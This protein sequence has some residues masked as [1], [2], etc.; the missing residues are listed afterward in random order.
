MIRQQNNIVFDWFDD[1]FKIFQPIVK[2]P[3]FFK[4]TESSINYK[5]I[6]SDLHSYNNKS[7]IT[8]IHHDIDPDM[9]PKDDLIRAHR[10]KLSFDN[11]QIKILD[12]YFDECKSL[13]NLCVDIWKKYNNVTSSW[14]LLKD[15]IFKHKYRSKNIYSH[16]QLIDLIIADLIQ[17][18]EDYI[19][20]HGITKLYYLKLFE[21]NKLNHQIDLDIWKI[22]KNEV[23]QKGFTFKLIKPKFIKVKMLNPEKPKKP[24]G[25]NVKKPAPDES[26]K[27]MIRMFCTHLSD[28]RDRKFRDKN[29]TFEMKYKDCLKSRILPIGFRNICVNGIF[30]NSL[31]KNTCQEFKKISNK[32]EFKNECIL[33]HDKVFNNYYIQVTFKKEIKKIQNR[34]KIGA[35]DPGEKIFLTLYSLENHGKIGDDMRIKILKAGRRI[36]KLQSI[37]DKK[38]NE[39]GKKIKN[40]SKLK[41]EINK[42][43]RRIKGYVNEIH[44][45]AAKYLC[46]NYENIILPEF[47]TKPMISDNKEK[48][49]KERIAKIEEESKRKEEY[50]KLR[51]TVKISNEV[52]FVLQMQ[53]HYS[54]KIYLKAKAKEYGTKVYNINEAYTS[55]ACTNCGRLSKEYDNKRVKQCKCG[56]KIDRDLNGSRNILIKSLRIMYE[57]EKK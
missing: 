18:K 26:L 29:F 1:K 12:I 42:I 27:A 47:E 55:Q 9:N 41:K 46:E 34:K 10:Y 33:I 36:R 23:I 14:Q 17:I 51:K 25:E 15:I 57:N 28:N 38:K 37:I 35:L 54:F 45:K 4:K 52:K 11:N 19:K 3:S 56:K 8:E 30:I 2:L 48:K 16:D 20:S 31:G 43:Y 49:E 50:L 13:Y 44:K 6:L 53:K 7:I 39:K 22:K 21:I 40:K 5:N 24:R 32:Y